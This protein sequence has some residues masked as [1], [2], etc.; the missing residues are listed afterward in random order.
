MSTPIAEEKKPDIV[1]K[2]FKPVQFKIPSSRDAFYFKWGRETLK[3]IVPTLHD[4]LHKLITLD[5]ALI[6]GS[7]AIKDEFIGP[8]CRIFILIG[9]IASLI[10]AFVGFA[11]RADTVNLNKPHE[12]EKFEENTIA[13]KNDWF[14]KSAFFLV[15][16]LIF[17]TAGLAVKL[18]F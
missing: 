12:I 3:E 18:C 15:L 5:V 2:R 14:R 11:P 7:F 16:S 1:P 17:A 4:I 6:G 10:C 13:Y 9:L 8:R